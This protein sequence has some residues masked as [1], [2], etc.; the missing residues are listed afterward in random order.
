MKHW[1]EWSKWE[2]DHGVVLPTLALNDVM[3][4][5][6]IAARSCHSDRT[7]KRLAVWNIPV[8]PPKGWLRALESKARSAYPEID[9]KAGRA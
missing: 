8:P 4:V 1:V 7:N 9:W 6:K 2:R 3:L 5:A